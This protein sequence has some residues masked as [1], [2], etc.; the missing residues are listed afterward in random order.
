MKQ[1]KVLAVA[2]A[3][4]SLAA[5]VFGAGFSL[6][7]GSARSLAL[8]TEVTA[9]PMG[10]ETLLHNAAG[11]T[12]LPGTQVQAGVSIIRPQLTVETLTAEGWVRTKPS[13]E[14]WPIPKAFASHQLMD[15]VW[16]GLGIFS[17]FG[18]GE[19]WPDEWPGR[20]NSQKLTI[21]TFDI[22]PSVA[23]KVTDQISVAAGFRAQYADMEYDRALPTAMGDLQMNLEGDAWGYGY[24]IGILYKAADWLS[25]G[26]HYVS[27]IKQEI[28]GHADY[29]VGYTAGEA[30]LTLPQSFS[31]GASWKPIEKLK[32]NAGVVYTMWSSYDELTI[33]FEEP[34]FGNPALK[35]SSSE[36]NWN[37][38]FRY[39]L[40]AE[41]AIDQHWAIRA[42]Y[43]YDSTP[44]DDEYA[45]Y[46]VPANDRQIL[47]LGLGYNAERFAID[48]GY[49]YLF[50]GT[51]RIE[52]R[53]EEGILKS[54]FSDGHS[55][56]LAMSFT[57]RF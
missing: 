9:D 36:K 12:E 10:P 20:Y 46:I 41:Y 11:M 26:L 42:G 13:R 49:A 29:Q 40:G 37:D 45:D 16:L 25:F 57:Y 8:G 2:L 38:V 30:D 35:T 32:V 23:F 15:N 1:M 47:S 14:T 54:N 56:T 17:R 52:A 18:L 22:N 53:P 31:L 33:T 39:Q 7:D 43:V 3:I 19:D 4:A 27:E 34:L 55:S 28:E 51:R 44:V 24:N 48:V 5:P 50:F 6:Y 21:E